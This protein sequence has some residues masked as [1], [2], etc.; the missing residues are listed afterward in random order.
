MGSPRDSASRIPAFGFTCLLLALGCGACASASSDPGSQSGSLKV[1]TFTPAPGQPVP[2]SLLST[3]ALRLD[4]TVRAGY[5]CFTMDGTPVA[6]PAGFSAAATGSGKPEVRSASGNVLR[7]G[8]AYQLN[9]MTIQSAG[10][11]CSAKGQNVTAVLD[12]HATG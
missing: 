7:I 12:V 11:T 3:S 2:S 1:V 8:G 9:V 4:V 6:W 10:D 5:A